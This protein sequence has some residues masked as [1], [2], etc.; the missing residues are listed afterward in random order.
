M[1]INIVN[2]QENYIDDIFNIEQSEI[3]VP[4]SKESLSGLIRQ[5]FIIFRVMLKDDEVIGYYS[6]Q[7]ICDE[8]YINN[9]AIKREYQ[10]QGLGTKLFED[11]IERAE[12][13]EVKALTLEV[14]KNNNKAIG[15]YKKFGFKVEGVR[16]NYYKNSEDALIMWRR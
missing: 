6:F 9:I 16:K 14:G 12:K 13:F 1:E 5:Q 3:I 10:S 4:W 7:K 2:V 15:L 11:L 8:G